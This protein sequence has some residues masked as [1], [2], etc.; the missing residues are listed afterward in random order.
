MKKKTKKQ[1]EE[2]KSLAKSK[3]WKYK[4]WE[5][6][7]FIG[8]IF[9]PFYL[10]TFTVRWFSWAEFIFGYDA[11][12]SILNLW[13]FGVFEIFAVGLVVFLITIW[14]KSN[15]KNAKRNS[16][17]E[18]LGEEYWEYDDDDEDYC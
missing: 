9:V 13:A 18:V 17:K 14:I 10:G 6:I 4:F 8:F 3:F 5:V 12:K 7:A 1:E 16:E 2:I 15:L 11:T